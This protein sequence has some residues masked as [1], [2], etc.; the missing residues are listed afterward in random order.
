MM[1]NPERPLARLGKL[2][3]MLKLRENNPTVKSEYK[4]FFTQN[5]ILN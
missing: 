5:S 3:L 2:F 1:D 4:M